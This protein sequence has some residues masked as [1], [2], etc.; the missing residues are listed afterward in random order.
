MNRSF[1]IKIIGIGV[2]TLL[3]SFALMYINNMIL[4]RQARQSQVVSELARSS[5]GKQTLAGPV[6]VIPYT[7]QYDE[8]QNTLEGNKVVR[9][10]AQDALYILPD[11]L[12]LNGDFTTGFKALGL[13]KV[14]FYNLGGSVSGQFKIPKNLVLPHPKRISSVAWGSAYVSVG[15]SD[16]RGIGSNPVLTWNGIEQ[17]F[18]VGTQHELLGKGMHADIGQ[19]VGYEGLSVPF[20]F[21]LALRGMESFNSYPL[22]M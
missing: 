17:P 5:A 9:Y 4:E 16:T 15:M 20:S 2:L 12:E 13:Y 3:M 10:Q 22:V 8:I 21:D 19:I 18:L 1:L 7:E 11:Q 6:L 14:L